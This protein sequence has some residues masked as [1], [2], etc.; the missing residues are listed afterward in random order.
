MKSNIQIVTIGILVG[1]DISN[2]REVL[3]QLMD[4]DYPSIELIISVNRTSGIEAADCVEFIRNYSKD[5][6]KNVIVNF[7][8]KELGLNEHARYIFENSSGEYLIYN[9][10]GDTFWTGNTL[11]AFMEDFWDVFGAVRGVTVLYDGKSYIGKNI[12]KD[13]EYSYCFK[14]KM[15]T[16]EMFEENIPVRELLLK[17]YDEIGKKSGVADSSNYVLKHDI[18]NFHSALAKNREITLDWSSRARKNVNYLGYTNINKLQQI[19]T[20]I[21]KD[22][23]LGRSAL[24]EEVSDIIHYRSKG[25]WGIS[26]SDETMLH[27][28][29]ELA[30]SG[31]V[32]N[33]NLLVE[34]NKNNKIKIAAICDEFPIWQSCIQSI[35]KEVAKDK[36]FEIHL[37]H[38]PFEHVNKD[39]QDVI[40]TLKDYE[41]DGVPIIL[42]DKYDLAK[43]SPDCIIYTKPYD[44]QDGWDIKNIS[45]IVPKPVFIP[46]CMWSEHE[47][48]EL[49]QITFH[50]PVHVL[51]WKRL[52]YSKKH[53]E[54]IMKY[55][56]NRE[57]H[58]CIG[59]PRFD[60]T[61]EDMSEEEQN[62]YKSFKQRAGKRKIFFWNSHFELEREQ[63]GAARGTWILLGEKILEYFKQDKE[64]FLIWRPH[65]FFWNSLGKKTGNPNIKESYLNMLETFENIY[66]DCRRSY[67]PALY[68][69]DV[70]ISDNSSLI[71]GYLATNKPILFTKNRRE[72]ADAENDHLYY[73]YRF[74]EVMNFIKETMAGNDIKKEVRAEF[75]EQNY[76]LDS[77]KTCSR[78]LLDE[79][80]ESYQ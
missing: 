26:L 6:I 10:V 78:R 32:E 35:A 70:L 2:M 45:K 53:T 33:V 15:I 27:C 36:R 7:S 76:Y 66:V 4:Q 1:K 40:K 50:L 65:P 23:E 61:I 63:D 11:S 48:R 17:I 55:A 62:L 9:L 51:V 28:L 60:L 58:L 30:H 44:L 77:K 68:A 54:E 42:H 34:K 8:E 67:Y 56:Y 19:M 5:N 49:L 80:I 72:I 39:E 47:S 75:V 12:K 57:N 71:G 31:N 38:V 21:E 59:H 46:Y 22:K 18:N 14:T 16:P 79:I 24:M 52:S 3:R 64:A 69:S 43:E 74:E 25:E 20:I 41:D 29:A 13:V 37:V 73:A